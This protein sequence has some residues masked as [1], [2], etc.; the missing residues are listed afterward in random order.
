MKHF[1]LV[2][3]ALAVVL[4]SCHETADEENTLALTSEE[5]RGDKCLGIDEQCQSLCDCCGTTT[6]EEGSWFKWYCRPNQW[7]KEVCYVKKDMCRDNAIWQKFTS[8][9]KCKK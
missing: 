4:C 1:S 7:E 9:E 2:V 6:C 8:Q 5:G 3:F